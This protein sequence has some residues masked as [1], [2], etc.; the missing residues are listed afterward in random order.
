M[1]VNLERPDGRSV[2]E[3]ELYVARHMG[4]GKLERKLVMVVRAPLRNEC[5]CGHMYIGRSSDTPSVNCFLAGHPLALT[6]TVA[7]SCKMQC[8]KAIGSLT[9]VMTN[10]LQLPAYPASWWTGD[11]VLEVLTGFVP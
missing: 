11:V 9:Y 7:S 1:I 5:I 2:L 10:L 8:S 3:M 6:A 4:I